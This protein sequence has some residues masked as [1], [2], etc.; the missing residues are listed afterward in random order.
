MPTITGTD[1]QQYSTI[2]GKEKYVRPEGG[3]D[4]PNGALDSDSFLKLFIATLKNQSVD[5]T[6]DIKEIMQYTASMTTVQTNNANREA[7]ES[8]VETLKANSDYKSQFGLLPAI[9][10]MA[11][12]KLNTLKF[13]GKNK[14]EFTVFTPEVMKNASMQITSLTGAIVKEIPL[15]EYVNYKGTVGEDE[16]GNDLHKT[17]GLLNL[18][19]DGTNTSGTFAEKNGYRVKI[20]YQDES[21][22]NKE[23]NLGEYKVQ[24]VK[25]KEGVPYLNVGNLD[26]ELSDI[27][28]LRE[29]Q[30]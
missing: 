7:L 8:V 5:S 25:F 3:V 12:T 22:A 17:K 23:L 10:K 29:L 26:V 27:L 24:S 21:G 28:E 30:N 4:N 13:D 16:S 9:G 18:S 1:N 2:G 15:D 14:T 19:W 11:I 6:T 20:N